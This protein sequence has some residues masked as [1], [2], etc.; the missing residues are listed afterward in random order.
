MMNFSMRI[1]LALSLI[2]LNI[3]PSYSNAE[4][5]PLA[6]LN[7]G[8]RFAKASNVLENIKSTGLLRVA[9]RED[10]IPFGY[11]NL[12]GNLDGICLGFFDLI[13][14]KLLS[15]LKM[16]VITI[17]IFRSTLFNR[18]T[19]VEDNLVDLE[20]GPNT[21]REELQNKVAFSAPFFVTG[22]QFLI[23][24]EDENKFDIN[25]NL[26]Q[27]TIGVLRNTTTKEMISNRYP[28]ATLQEFQGVTGRMRGIQALQMGRINA[29]ASDGILL[30]G[31]ATLQGLSIPQEYILV[32]PYPLDCEY[33]GMILPANDPQWRDFVN[34]VI[35]ETESRELLKTWFTVIAPYVRETVNYCKNK[36]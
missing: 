5:S 32:P 23:R 4:E 21:I 29:F 35:K 28:D 1:L 27:M 7:K 2:V 20:C 3:F 12:D 19:L 8:G 18:F 9:I 22:L 14:T 31:E 36:N 34:S 30:I 16:Q 17:K 11:R 13:R 26:A 10:S 6:P 25:G 15:E 33:Y 24:E